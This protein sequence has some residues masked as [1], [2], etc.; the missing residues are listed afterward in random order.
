MDGRS[1]VGVV[2]GWAMILSCAALLA[3]VVLSE[4]VGV[5]VVLFSASPTLK[6]QTRN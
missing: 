2:F 1:V 4:G 3:V 5:V 6:T